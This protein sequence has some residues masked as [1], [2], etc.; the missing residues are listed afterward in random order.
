MNFSYVPHLNYFTGFFLWENLPLEWISMS[1]ICVWWQSM[2]TVP[3]YLDAR[4]RLYSNMYVYTVYYAYTSMLYNVLGHSIYITFIFLLF[5]K[6]VKDIFTKYSPFVN[7][8]ELKMKM[9]N[10][11]KRKYPLFRAFLVVCVS[12]YL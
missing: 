3:Y 12:L 8:F 6:V 7:Y 10:K 5:F 11:C 2:D 4:I 9:L 1:W